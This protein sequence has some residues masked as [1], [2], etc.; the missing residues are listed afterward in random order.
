MNGARNNPQ[1][2]TN[3][4]TASH[5]RIDYAIQTAF[6]RVAAKTSNMKL[7]IF[8]CHLIEGSGFSAS[9]SESNLKYWFWKCHFLNR[10]QK[11]TKLTGLFWSLQLDKM[12]LSAFNLPNCNWNTHIPM[13]L[14]RLGSVIDVGMKAP[15]LQYMKDNINSEKTCF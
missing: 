2:L 9:G 10:I 15:W 13:I 14:G 12:V 7:I 6:G 8:G 11:L 3:I 4:F 1:V 5:W